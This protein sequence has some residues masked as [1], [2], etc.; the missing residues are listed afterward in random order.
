MNST[1]GEVQALGDALARLTVEVRTTQDTRSDT[2]RLASWFTREP[3]PVDAD[4][5]LSDLELGEEFND[6][7]VCFWKN[8][9]ELRMRLLERFQSHLG[10]NSATDIQGFNR[11][12]GL[13]EKGWIPFDMP[14]G[15]ENFQ[16]LSPV[17]MH[18]HGVH[19]LN[20]WVQRRFREAELKKAREQWGTSLGDEEIVVCDKVI[21]VRNQ[22][23]KAYDGKNQVELYLANGEIGTVSPRQPIDALRQHLLEF[24]LDSLRLAMIGEAGRYAPEQPDL[25]VR[26]P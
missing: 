21:Q 5:V 6:L 17:R 13:N 24:V 25:P 20:R 2:L 7:E 10:L 19:E 16:I 12:L 3:Q 26:L 11:A 23:R 8:P 22:K 14:E 4:R 1:D 9:E 18:P 15:V